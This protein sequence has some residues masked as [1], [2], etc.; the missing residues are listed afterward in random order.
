MASP[1]SRRPSWSRTGPFFA[2]CAGQDARATTSTVAP[3]SSQRYEARHRP[4]TNLAQLLINGH[5]AP[6]KGPGIKAMMDRITLRTGFRVHAHAFRH[7]F[8]TVA[9]QL[10]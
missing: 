7:T 9:T 5:G 2:S 4:E 8:A 6:Y 1:C 3:S 10:G